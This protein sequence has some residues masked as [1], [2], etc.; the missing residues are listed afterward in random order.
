MSVK[1]K[2]TL[3]PNRSRTVLG[4][5][6]LEIRAK[7]IRS[8]EKLLDWD[9]LEKEIAN[10]RGDVRRMDNEETGLR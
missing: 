10:R 7:I 4:K 6:L 8:G 1:I 9:D 2:E 3:I 5:R